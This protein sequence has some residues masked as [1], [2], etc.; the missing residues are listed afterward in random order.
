MMI[1]RDAEQQMIYYQLDAGMS[2]RAS[3]MNVHAAWQHS[4]TLVI[5]YFSRVRERNLGKGGLIC[6]FLPIDCDVED[7]CYYVDL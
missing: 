2:D 7:W 4:N 1:G 6:L 3:H 5:A